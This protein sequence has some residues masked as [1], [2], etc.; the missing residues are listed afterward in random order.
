[1]RFLFRGRLDALPSAVR[2]LKQ[3]T[4]SA[5][6]TSRH[7]R[8]LKEANASTTRPSCMSRVCRSGGDAGTSC[9]LRIW[10]ESAVRLLRRGRDVT[11]ATPQRSQRVVPTHTPFRPLS[12]WKFVLTGFSV[13]NVFSL[14][15]APGSPY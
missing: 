4:M 3:R 2:G 8:S 12:V 14:W 5:G 11:Q 7:A 15:H 9:V 13:Q 6:V 1:M 10:G